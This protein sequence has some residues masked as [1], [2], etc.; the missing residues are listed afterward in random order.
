MVIYYRKRF[1]NVAF[2]YVSDDMRWGKQNLAHL[3]RNHL[4][5]IGNG[6]NEEKGES[7]AN[8]LQERTNKFAKKGLAPNYNSNTSF[9]FAL[10]SACNHTISSRGTF[11]MHAA[12]FAGGKIINEHS[13]G[14]NRFR[15]IYEYNRKPALKFR[16]VSEL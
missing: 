15:E 9:D 16:N 1:S 11:S 12:S 10:L 6:L 5:F 7:T 8:T 14:Y 2:I 13:P 3:S 4:Y